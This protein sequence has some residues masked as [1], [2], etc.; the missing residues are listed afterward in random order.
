MPAAPAGSNQLLARGKERLENKPGLAHGADEEHVPHLAAIILEMDAQGRRLVEQ[1]AHAA[2]QVLRDPD[3]GPHRQLSRVGH[4]HAFAET[5]RAM[6]HALFLRRIGRGKVLGLF[7]QQQAAFLHGVVVV[8]VEQLL[9]Q[10]IVERGQAIL[11]RTVALE[12]EPRAAGGTEEGFI[13]AIE[14]GSVGGVTLQAGR[15]T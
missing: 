15:G 6:Q 2:S 14:R 11:D 1:L 9:R 4:G 12:D 13:E 10:R 7:P 8:L 3:R 5:D